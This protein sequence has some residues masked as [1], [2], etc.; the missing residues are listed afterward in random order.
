MA[1][2]TYKTFLMQKDESA[3]TKTVDIKDFPDLGGSPETLEKTTLTDKM[4]TYIEGLQD[5]KALEFTANYD[6]DDLKKLEALAGIEKDYAVWFGGTEAGG[7]VTPT[8]D[9]GKFVLKGTLSVYVTG[10]GTNEVV[11][12]KI[13]IVPSTVISRDATT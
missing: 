12:M 1:I 10:A 4:K 9:N 6:L 3:W 13:T 5:I 7:T 8:G 2:S 11:E